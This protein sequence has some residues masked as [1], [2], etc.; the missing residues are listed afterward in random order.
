MGRRLAIF[1]FL[2]AGAAGAALALFPHHIT[3]EIVSTDTG[4]PSLCAKMRAG[5]EFVLSF[6][7]S[8]NRR[9]VYDTI[10]TARDQVVV[11]KSRYDSF[12][13]GM[14]EHST[15]EGTFRVAEDGWIEWT[16][17]RPMPEVVVRVGRV[18]NHTLH[19]KG[20][21]IPL[22]SLAPPGTAVA[23]RSRTY[24]EFDLWKERCLR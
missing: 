15:A 9:P 12:G 10:R 16:I 7:H 6:T 3:L 24:S 2:G 11:V 4:R 8:V 19:L 13:A 21:E 22:A 5:E 14:P 18:A 1:A 17:N 23:L 20:R